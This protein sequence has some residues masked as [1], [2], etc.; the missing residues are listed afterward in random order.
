MAKDRPKWL[1]EL[2]S[3]FRRHRQ[4]HSGWFVEVNRDRLRVVSTELPRRPDEPPDAPPK[5]RAYTLATPPGPATFNAALQE[6]SALFDA[7]MADEWRWP[8]PEAIAGPDDER[9]LTPASLQRLV[10][11]LRGSIEGEK[12]S[13]RTW[14]RMYEPALQRL[15]ETAGERSWP[16]D[17]ELLEATLRRWPANSRARQMAHDRIRRLWREAGWEWPA[18][19]VEL[20]GNGKAKKSPD[21][22]RGFTD[23]EL[24][25]L[26]A[27]IERSIQRHKL[28]P[29]DLVAWD[30]LMAFGLR[31]AELQGLEITT[32][33]G[34]PIAKVSRE[35][36]SSKGA[37]GARNVP[38]VAPDG[39][40]DD[41][42]SLWKRWKEYGLPPSLVAYW[43]PG[44]KMAQ[45]LARLQRQHPVSIALDAELKPYSC[46]H[47]F[48]LRLAQK[49]GLHVREAA[50]LMGHSPAVHLSTYGRRLDSPKLVSSV[51]E[52][53][54]AR[55]VGA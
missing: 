8:D 34:V 32:Q 13:E 11:Q 27:R 1:A 25:E 9:R 5:R 30:C 12:V 42:H 41:F 46:R 21:G 22:V 16:A 54:T 44:E 3:G 28:T 26:R 47:A 52:R 10:G 19:L 29:S 53:L 39:W 20:R 14:Q 2:S 23:D 38:A 49:L 40:P 31:P 48:A 18:Q 50:D 36:R 4:G 24:A 15:I 37:S 7:V 17:R 33:K 51:I 55:Q 6:C 43:S 45:Q 35:K